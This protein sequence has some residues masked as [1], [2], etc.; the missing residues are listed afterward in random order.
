MA[1]TQKLYPRATVKRVVKAHSNRNVSKN[2]DILIFLDYMLFMQELMRES[3]IQS[4][5]VGEKN[6]SPNSVRKVTEKT[7]R[8]FKG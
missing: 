8:R 6:I 3:S 2:A 7:L 1:A 4:R 5:K